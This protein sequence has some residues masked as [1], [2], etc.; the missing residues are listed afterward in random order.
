LLYA[1]VEAQ[2]AVRI[3]E[4]EGDMAALPDLREQ[5]AELQRQYD[6]MCNL[7]PLT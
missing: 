2:A 6:E 3:V 5:A 7:L 1:L 4:R